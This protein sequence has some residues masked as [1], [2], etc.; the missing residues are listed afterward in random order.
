MSLEQVQAAAFSGRG[1]WTVL[2]RQHVNQLKLRNASSYVGLSV[3][4]IVVVRAGK[5]VMRLSE[6][7][8]VGP[9]L[10]LACDM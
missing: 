7:R 5:E 3:D 9:P 4:R 8:K 1:S 10:A 6:G 2:A